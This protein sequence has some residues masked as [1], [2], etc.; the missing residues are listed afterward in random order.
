M[1]DIRE[2][3]ILYIVLECKKDGRVQSASIV[4]CSRSLVRIVTVSQ[5]YDNKRCMQ[6]VQPDICTTGEGS[7][8]TVVH[9]V[10]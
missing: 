4:T 1:T 10:L 8:H 3:I 5:L 2:G 6:K 7:A 9:Y